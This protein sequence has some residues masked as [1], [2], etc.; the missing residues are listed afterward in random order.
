M[1]RRRYGIPVMVLMSLICVGVLLA[2]NTIT[3]S[4]DDGKRHFCN[5]HE[6]DDA[7]LLNQRSGSPCSRGDTWGVEG[8]SIWVDRGCRADFQMMMRGGAGYEPGGPGY[9]GPGSNN[10]GQQIRCSSN[11]MNYVRCRVSGK[12]A[13]A[14]MNRQISGSACVQGET[15]GWDKKG[16]WVDKGCR[17]DFTVWYR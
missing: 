2:Q 4:S 16:L 15:W 17:A 9:G 13:G 11:N 5:M 7:R 10:Q 12:I 1:D 14:Q 3:C 8:H 6:F